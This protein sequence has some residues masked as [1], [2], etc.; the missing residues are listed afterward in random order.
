V[1]SAIC[2]NVVFVREFIMRKLA[3]IAAAL[4]LVASGSVLAQKP[5]PMTDKQMDKVTAG[6]LANVVLV[7]LVDV[8]KNNVQVVAPIGVTAAV[9]VLGTAVAGTGQA[10]GNQTQRQ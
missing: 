2:V 6:V 1:T 10:L 9:G 3:V 4:G 7:D 5:V 8:N